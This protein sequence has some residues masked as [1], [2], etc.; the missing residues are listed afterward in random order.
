MKVAVKYCGNCNPQLDALTFIDELKKMNSDIQFVNSMDDD[1]DALLIISGC[2]VDCA[3]R[4]NHH[5]LVCS[6]RGLFYE[7]KKINNDMLTSL[8]SDLLKAKK[9][10][11][12]R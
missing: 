5:G 1:G 12:L 7:G 2:P 3:S 11:M 8:V 10:L 6:V 4:P 9:A